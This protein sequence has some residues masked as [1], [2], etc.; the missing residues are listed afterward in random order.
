MA[1]LFG[2]RKPA[3]G[4][5]GVEPV[6]ASTDCMVQVSTPVAGLSEEVT[7]TGFGSVLTFACAV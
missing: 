3:R 4:F 7:L 6:I 2:G 5:A 1:A